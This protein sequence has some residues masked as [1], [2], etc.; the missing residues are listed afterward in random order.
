MHD[1]AS[2]PNEILGFAI[3]KGGAGHTMQR[4]HPWSPPCR[5]RG[6]FPTK[7]LLLVTCYCV[8]KEYTYIFHMFLCVRIFHDFEKCVHVS[9]K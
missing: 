5:S 6:N 4:T 9:Q 1:I 8:S 2:G 3:L 7:E